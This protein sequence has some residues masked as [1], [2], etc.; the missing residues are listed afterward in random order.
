MPRGLSGDVTQL[1]SDHHP[2]W[3]RTAYLWEVKLGRG[4]GGWILCLP[5]QHPTPSARKAP[6]GHRA[7]MDC[8]KSVPPI[9]HLAGEAWSRLAPRPAA[10]HSAVGR[11]P[12]SCPGLSFL[13][14]HRLPLLCGADRGGLIARAETVLFQS[15]REDLGG[16]PSKIQGDRIAGRRHQALRAHSCRPGQ[17]RWPWCVR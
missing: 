6:W 5:P 16:A 7:E 9:P 12:S 4:G 10:G 2:A 14:H 17:S 13:F 3:C 1:G 15:P 8:S 11:E